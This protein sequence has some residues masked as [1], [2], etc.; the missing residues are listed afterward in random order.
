MDSPTQCI[1]D[2]GFY[3]PGIV[4]GLNSTYPIICPADPSCALFRAIG[5][6]C[7]DQ[8]LRQSLYEVENFIA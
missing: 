5:T 1:A 3:C 4:E 8:D 7:E 2:F 6:F